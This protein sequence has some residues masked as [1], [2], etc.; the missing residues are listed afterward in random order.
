MFCQKRH[1]E[2][3]HWKKGSRYCLGKCVNAACTGL[4]QDNEKVM[5]AEHVR[6]VMVFFLKVFGLE[7]R[8]NYCHRKQL[9]RYL[10][11]AVVNTS[12]HLKPHFLYHNGICGMVLMRFQ[13]DLRWKLKAC[14]CDVRNVLIENSLTICQILTW[15]TSFTAI[16]KFCINCSFSSSFCIALLADFIL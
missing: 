12:D 14:L 2:P 8:M 6:F 9:V 7:W 13:A 16:N 1:D 15:Y 11:Q 5:W 10:S 3:F 4:L